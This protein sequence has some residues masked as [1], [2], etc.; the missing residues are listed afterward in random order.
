[1][2][3]EVQRMFQSWLLKGMHHSCMH[4]RGRVCDCR[5]HSMAPIGAMDSS[6]VTVHPWLSGHPSVKLIYRLPGYVNK[7]E[8][9]RQ[10]LF[11]AQNAMKYYWFAC[12]DN[13]EFGLGQSRVHCISNSV[14]SLCCMSG[15]EVSLSSVGMALPSTEVLPTTL[16]TMKQRMPSFCVQYVVASHNYPMAC[17]RITCQDGHPPSHFTLKG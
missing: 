9:R 6:H 3:L 17:H 14:P 5:P 7:S 4:R 2:S 8:Y 16:L 11:N 13:R 10:I 12:L 1:M 15:E